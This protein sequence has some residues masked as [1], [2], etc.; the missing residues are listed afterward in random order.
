MKAM[1]EPTSS[2]LRFKRKQ[3]KDFLTANSQW[4]FNCEG[5]FVSVP[6]IDANIAGF[7][8]LHIEH[9]IPK[10]HG[11]SD[12][13]DNLALACIDCNLH[14]RPNIAGFDP[15]TSLISQLY[16]PRKHKWEDHFEWQGIT[17]LG[18]T[19]IGRATVDVLC[20]NSEEQLHL[21]LE[22]LG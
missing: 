1:C 13:F 9:I 15:Q 5:E 20:L 22:I 3:G 19:A 14:K 16:H 11:G 4:I 21:R 7:A 6:T 10:K 17:I 18:K 8:A 12:N 2:F